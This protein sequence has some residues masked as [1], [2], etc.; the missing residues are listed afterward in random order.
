VTDITTNL[1][2]KRIKNWLVKASVFIAEYIK[3]LVWQD[4]KYGEI[5]LKKVML[6]SNLFRVRAYTISR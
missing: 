4:K 6:I 2:G 5:F 3:R 1:W